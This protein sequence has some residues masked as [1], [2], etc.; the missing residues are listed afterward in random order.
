MSPVLGAA[1]NINILFIGKTMNTGL[2][3]FYFENF[4][5]DIEVEKMVSIIY[6]Q[7]K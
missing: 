3:M 4:Q 5:T 1:K 2:F 6:V 7:I